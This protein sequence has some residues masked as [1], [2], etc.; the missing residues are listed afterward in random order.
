VGATVLCL[1]LVYVLVDRIE[2]TSGWP[3]PYQ[4]RESRLDRSQYHAFLA[5]VQDY[6]LAKV[7]KRANSALLLTFMAIRIRRIIKIHHI[8]YIVSNQ[9]KPGL[10]SPPF[11]SNQ[12]AREYR[13]SSRYPLSAINDATYRQWRYAIQPR[14][15][16]FQ[17]HTNNSASNLI[18]RLVIQTE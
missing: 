17:L 10:S 13:L 1:E 11:L 2:L 9:D 12:E 14:R 8:M 6:H 16:F 3:K 7:P 4:P 18:A 5:P 15:P